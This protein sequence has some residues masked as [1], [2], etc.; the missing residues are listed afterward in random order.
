MAN[1]LDLEPDDLRERV[2]ALTMEDWYVED[3][4]VKCERAYYPR[5]CRYSYEDGT[6][7][8]VRI[9]MRTRLE[10]IRKLDNLKDH[11]HEM[12]S[13]MRNATTLSSSI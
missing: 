8:K 6:C 2:A 9:F 1:F 3:F 13:D 5:P 11:L 7:D 10:V 12:E 4:Q